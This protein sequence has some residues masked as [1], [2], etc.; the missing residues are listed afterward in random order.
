MWNIYVRV[1]LLWLLQR[2]NF[3]FKILLPLSS[4]YQREPTAL[5]IPVTNTNL[6]QSQLRILRNYVV[7]NWTIHCRVTTRNLKASFT[8]TMFAP[9]NSLQWCTVKLRKTKCLHYIFILSNRLSSTQC[10]SH[11]QATQRSC[12][13]MYHFLA[14]PHKCNKYGVNNRSYWNKIA[15]DSKF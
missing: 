9:Y 7:T 14:K 12:F 6:D 3:Y 13:S 4:W 1:S 11:P 15:Q 10:F 5:Y 2:P 8:K